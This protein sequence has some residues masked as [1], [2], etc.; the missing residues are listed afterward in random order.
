MVRRTQLVSA[1]AAIGLLPFLAMPSAG[2]VPQRGNATAAPRPPAE[3]LVARSANPPGENGNFQITDQVPYTLDG[4]PADFGPHVDDQRAMYWSNQTKPANF[5]TPTGTPATPRAGVRIYRDSFGVPLIYGKNGYD[6]W[7]GAGFAAATDR[8]FEMDAI[9]RLGE[10]RLAELTGPKTVPADLQERIVTYTN[11]EYQHMFKALPKAGRQAIRGYAAGAQARIAQVRANP[12][13]LPGEYVLLSSAPQRWT[14]KD[15]MA[16]G[17]YITRNIAS[18]G[19][20]EM[21][22]VAILHQLEHKFGK[23]NGRQIFLDLFPDEEPHAIVSITG[24]RFSNVARGDRSAADQARDAR[25]AMAYAEHLPLSLAFGAGTG[26]SAAPAALPASAAGTGIAPQVAADVRRAARSVDG[27]AHSLHGGSFA[28]ALAGSRTKSGHAMVASNPQLDYSY[29]SELWEL[30]VHG[31][32]YD[33]R[34]IGVPSIPTVGIGHTANVAWALTTGYSKTIDSFIETTRKNPIPGGPP[35]YLHNGFWRNENCRTVHVKYRAAPQGVPTGPPNQT[36]NA[37]VC[38]TIHGPVVATTKNGKRARSMAFAQ[39]KQDVQ[40]V[41]G[42]L[43][44]DRAKNLHQVAAGVKHVR[45]NENIIAADSHGHIGYWHPGRYFRHAP[46]IDQ[47][48]PLRGTGSQDEQGYIPFRQM[49][50]VINP[51]QGFVGNWNNKPAH[52]WLDG[53]LSGTNSRP[54]GPITRFADLRRLLAHTHHA[55]AATMAKIERRVG[56][57]D[58]RYIGYLPILH[59]LRNLKRLSPAA[60]AARRLMLGWDGR[61]YAPGA[62]G[63]SSPR[64]TP[65]EEVTDG[66]AATVFVTFTDKIKNILFRTLPQAARARLDTLSKESHQYDVTPLDNDAIGVLLPGFSSLNGGVGP[67]RR[68]VVERNA[69]TRAA[70]KMVATY[71]KKPGTWRRPHGVSHIDSLSGVIGPSTVMPFQDR[72]TWVQE[73]AFTAG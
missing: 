41:T 22:N 28:F 43:K 49:P 44:W 14:I 63:G 71:G 11:H 45:W 20:L 60:R 29:P 42:I 13:L 30:E 6:V 68:A 66:P 12:A 64:S 4:D 55:T 62:P 46:G 10:G 8:L 1:I 57:D 9:R 34:G 69:L 47:R 25:R 31:G 23:A 15:T 40:T 67:H 17:V 18:Q 73:V 59:D 16:A 58:H 61:A 7:Y 70:A 53:D 32:G 5:A 35:Q 52:G 56:E 36:E 38:R 27:W 21:A 2:S 19:G 39:W 3:R 54:G 72:G 24:R 48:F 50:H 33:A 26:N 65:P 37:R 51:P